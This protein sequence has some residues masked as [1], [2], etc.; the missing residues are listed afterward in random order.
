MAVSFKLFVES[1]SSI[2]GEEQR[3]RRDLLPLASPA[4]GFELIKDLLVNLHQ[5]IA[6]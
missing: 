3:A 1:D 2:P 6:N 5:L 4:F